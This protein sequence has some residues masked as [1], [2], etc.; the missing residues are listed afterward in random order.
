M[1]SR[2]TLSFLI[3]ALFM[4]IGCKKETTPLPEAPT[5]DQFIG[6]FTMDIEHQFGIITQYDSVGNII[7]MGNDTLNLKN[8]NMAITQ[9]GQTDTLTISNIIKGFYSN[10][11]IEVQ[12]LISNDTINLIYD[13]SDPLRMNNYVIGK[14]W[15]NQDSIFMDYQWNT[16]DI[17]SA[18]ALP[19]RGTVMGKGSR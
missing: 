4:N 17:W 11:N 18:G 6:N 12:G 5:N 14:I 13:K 9:Q 1:N 8:Q 19:E 10:N 16:S 3:L 2:T 7:Y 15:I